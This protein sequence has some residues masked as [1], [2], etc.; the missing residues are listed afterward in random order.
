MNRLIRDASSNLV[1]QIKIKEGFEKENS[2]YD[3]KE[4]SYEFL[5]QYLWEASRKAARPQLVSFV[6]Q[7]IPSITIDNLILP[8][9]QKK[10]LANIIIQAKNMKTVYEQWGFKSSK[11]SGSR[12]GGLSALFYGE[13]G[14]GKTMAAEVIANELGIDLFRM[15]LSLV[16]SKYIGETEKN[17]R[18]V[19]DAAE[20]GGCVLFFDEADALF[21]KRSEV[22]SAHD[23]YANIEVGYLLQRMETYKGI[24]IL[25]TNMKNAIDPAFV[26]RLRFFVAFP[27]PDKKSREKIW[28]HSFPDSIPKDKLYFE[29]LSKMNI[30][31]GNIHS[32]SL[33]ASFLAV[34]KVFQ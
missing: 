8:E 34:M 15:D 4:A 12:L 24:V 19:F 23:R 32:I 17:L 29:E 21:G 11:G 31:G 33:N 13:S 20:A 2:G 30:S 22:S 5:R 9:K 25:A 1:S 26:R 27:F 16:V 3:E 18:Q 6:N 7:I 10:L 14:T 28:E